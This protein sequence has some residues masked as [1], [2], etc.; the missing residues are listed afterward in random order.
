MIKYR[1]IKS[2]EGFTENLSYLALVAIRDAAEKTEKEWPIK[3]IESIFFIVGAPHFGN[4]EDA[5]T[6][7]EFC[8][9]LEN[10]S[11]H[12]SYSQS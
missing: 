9:S 2:G 6:A 7:H 1:L 8:A 10:D 12:V 11:F 4:F 3:Q 5:N